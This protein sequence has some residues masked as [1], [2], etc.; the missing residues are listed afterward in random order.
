MSTEL[1]ERIVSLEFD[2]RQ[3]EKNTK[4]TMTTL[5]K[6]KRSLKLEGATKGLENVNNAANKMDLSQ[7]EKSIDSVGQKFSALEVVG[8]TALANIANK[9]TNVGISLVK[10]LTVDQLGAGW[11]KYNSKIESTQTLINA[12]GLSLEEVN[13]HLGALMW[14][15]DETSYSFAEMV[16]ALGQ[17]ATTGKDLNELI[18]MIEGI[19][20]ATASA[21]KTGTAFSIVI[22]NLMQSFSSGFLSKMDWQ[23]LEGQGVNTEQLIQ[24]LIETGELLGKIQKGEVTKENFASTLSKRWADQEVMARAFSQWSSLMLEAY[25]VMENTDAFDTAGEAIDSLKDKYPDWIVKASQSAQQAKSLS[26]AIGAIRDAVS[27]GWMRSFEIIFGDFHQAVDLWTEVN[28]VFWDIFASGE[29]LRNSIFSDAFQKTIVKT[30]VHINDLLKPINAVKKELFDINDAD[31]AK[32]ALRQESSSLQELTVGWQELSDAQN[33]AYVDQ[34]NKE[35]KKALTIQQDF[36]NRQK[37]IEDSQAQGLDTAEDQYKLYIEMVETYGRMDEALLVG[38][39]YSS[40]QAKSFHEIVEQAD[41]LGMSVEDVVDNMDQINGRWVLIDIFRKSA[42]KLLQ[43][44][45]AIR[46]SYQTTFYGT[47]DKDTNVEKRA[48]NIYDVL[49]AIHKF[50]ETLKFDQENLEDLGRTLNGLFAILD[51]IREVVSIPL[52]VAF[53]VLQGI[54]D[55]LNTDIL[56]LTGNV[57]DA[58]VNLVKWVKELLPIE[59]GV[60]YIADGIVKA[61][62]AIR[63]WLEDFENISPEEYADHIFAGGKKAVEA[64]LNVLKQ[65][66]TKLVSFIFPLGSE[67]GENTVAGFSEG[68]KT[69]ART[70]WGVLLSFGETILETVKNVLGIHSPSTEFFAIAW[71]CFLGFLN[72]IKEGSKKVFSALKDFGL[73]CLKALKDIPWGNIAAITLGAGFIAFFV[74]VIKA[75]SNLGYVIDVVYNLVGSVADVLDGLYKA[76]RRLSITA[77]V[78]LIAEAV[79]SIAEA[80]LLLAAALGVLSLIQ[81]ERLWSSVGALG[82]ISA[83]A[84]LLLAA[85]AHLVRL[86][87]KFT[88]KDLVKGFASLGLAIVALGAVITSLVVAAAIMDK[89]DTVKMIHNFLVLL[90]AFALFATGLGILLNKT[91]D[92]NKFGRLSIIMKNL[93]LVLLS[94]ALVTTLVGHIRTGTL[95][96]GSIAIAVFS[97]I[98]LALAAVTKI[99]DPM[100][101]ENMK[102]MFAGLS[103]VLLSMAAAVTILGGIKS[104]TLS[105]G[106]SVVT[107][108]SI[109]MAGLMAATRL[110]GGS[111][112]MIGA[113]GLFAG[114]A[115][116]L[117][118]MALSVKILK[119]VSPE[120]LRKGL[121]AVAS[122]GLIVA[123]LIA[124]TAIATKGAVGGKGIWEVSIVLLAASVAIGIL[125]GIAALLGQLDEKTLIKGVASVTVLAGAMALLMVAAGKIPDKFGSLITLT[126]AMTILAGIAALLTLLDTKKLIGSIASLSVL[127]IAFAGMTKLLKTFKISWGEILTIAV[128][129]ALMAALATVMLILDNIKNPKNALISV[130]ALSAL[131]AAL[132]GVVALLGAIKPVT[133]AATSSLVALVAMALSATGLI[134]ILGQMDDLKNAERNCILLAATLTAF[135]GIIALYGTLGQLAAE[136]AGPIAMVAAAILIFGVIAGAI[137][138][139]TKQSDIDALNTGIEFLVTMATGLG[140]FFASILTGFAAAGLDLIPYVGKV[141]SDFMTNA[142]IFFDGASNLKPGA[143]ENVKGICEALLLMTANGAI[144]ELVTA[145]TH[146]PPM[147]TF[148]LQLVAFGTAIK[149]FSALME[150]SNIDSEKTEKAVKVGEMFAKLA[151]A[152]P[153]TSLLSYVFGG[154]LGTFA[155][156]MEDFAD[157]IVRVSVKLSNKKIDPS[158]MS[159]AVQAGTILS[160][161]AKDL[162]DAS[163]FPDWLSGNTRMDL[164]TFAE[165]MEE[166]VGAVASLADPSITGSTKIGTARLSANTIERAKQMAEIGKAFAEVYAELPWKSFNAPINPDNMNSGYME[167][168]TMTL[169]EFAEQLPPFI[170]NA[171][172]AIHGIGMAIASYPELRTKGDFSVEI[173]TFKALGLAAAEIQNAIPKITKKEEPANLG[174]FGTQI[175]GFVSGMNA[176]LTSVHLANQHNLWN[177]NDLEM[178]QTLADVA[179]SFANTMSTI[180]GSY[181]KI[182]ESVG[183]IG[184]TIESDLFDNILF[185]LGFRKS[186]TLFEV[187]EKGTANSSGEGPL[188]KFGHDIYNFYEWIAKIESI[189]GAEHIS[190]LTNVVYKSAKLF[191]EFGIGQAEAYVSGFV[192]SKT[193]IVGAIQ[194]LLNVCKET[195][196]IGTSSISSDLLATYDKFY[197]FGVYL[198]SGFEVGLEESIRSAVSQAI[199]V[200]NAELIEGLDGTLKIRPVLDMTGVDATFNKW[201]AMRLAPGVTAATASSI[202]G[203]YSSNANQNGASNVKEIVKELKDGGALG[204]TYYI[205]KVD[206][207]ENTDVERAVKT[208][209]K[210]AKFDLRE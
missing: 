108:F 69:G 209:V 56:G 24:S 112:V 54:A 166:Y 45:Q 7:A 130:V 161:F 28:N 151:A 186:N 77:S 52:K 179:A 15:S 101:V 93:V 169:A 199:S 92:L 145:F 196:T 127:L 27:T 123:G 88:G 167:Y 185:A 125:G 208:I 117:I 8:I 32:Q 29:E 53:T 109:L 160:N 107:Y 40:E 140:R 195:L 104:E 75:L 133:K 156:Q 147:A 178:L 201:K 164:G 86:M 43:V 99:V 89:L 198:A 19:A 168:Y 118:A 2:N 91:N 34:Y 4:Q 42:E 129:S 1:D 146:L 135:A 106:I 155:D 187:Y 37:K 84:L 144:S 175:A 50:I 158:K 204:D 62:K 153:D 182:G 103:L 191:E 120:E 36:A 113:G 116:A 96:K 193:Q 55:D 39:G 58:I 44:I 137:G 90:V 105:K 177:G 119:N 51:L 181:S 78:A 22:S 206:Y 18:P 25:S 35:Y 149:T 102:S 67:M 210:A 82:A 9:A 207:T 171:A 126:V 17:A 174:L 23:S 197:M 26:E 134:F 83:M 139:V 203:L 165:Q 10:S 192:D 68:I 152:L 20:V 141:L 97:G 184:S 47:T 180:G 190:E 114:V 128:L 60:Q 21:G 100:T 31:Q 12:T 194:G 74:T 48:K 64:L 136:A 38:L 132:V 163:S 76:I 138:Y 98:L 65:A 85:M 200:I 73:G 57:G 81:P 162:P 59:E 61:F 66:F 170:E 189:S 63:Q 95:I 148:S 111:A 115:A 71:N 80:I 131:L 49:A 11:D 159:L 124:V 172:E 72:G 173:G 121:S 205:E 41:K 46:D 176:A 70:L 6:L 33:N 30:G 154:N 16:Q 13:D 150:D 143:V 202:S 5:Q 79:E 94:L 3:F 183:N 142:E 157:A 110:M 87:G 14:F 188:Q 122:L